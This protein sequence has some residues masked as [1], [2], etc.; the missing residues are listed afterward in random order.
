MHALLP[1][2]ATAVGFNLVGQYMKS[3]VMGYMYDYQES[4]DAMLL[5]EV[6][7]ATCPNISIERV[8]SQGQVNVA[9]GKTSDTGYLS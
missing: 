6:R 2:V 3:M 8:F 1:L 4:G 7:L 5:P 9:P